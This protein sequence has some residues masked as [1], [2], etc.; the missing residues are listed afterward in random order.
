M[1]KMKDIFIDLSNGDRSILQDE[2]IKLLFLGYHA[3]CIDVMKQIMYLNQAWIVDTN[4]NE[5]RLVRNADVFIPF[6]DANDHLK[7]LING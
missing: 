5:V 6:S 3:D 7:S 1:G 2:D 4:M